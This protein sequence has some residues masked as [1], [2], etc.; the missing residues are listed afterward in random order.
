[1][2]PED[3][4]ESPALARPLRRCKTLANYVHALKNRPQRNGSPAE[5]RN[6]SKSDIDAIQIVNMALQNMSD[7]TDLTIL[8]LCSARELRWASDITQCPDMSLTS[9]SSN[10]RQFDFALAL[11]GFALGERYA[12]DSS[13]ADIRAWIRLLS[14][15]GAEQ[16][17]S[18]L[19]G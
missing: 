14:E 7:E 8:R 4:A 18:T 13:K 2:G 10:H 19:N 15:A 9:D 17:V 16:S 12:S 1:M 6:L 5:L 3:V 11:H